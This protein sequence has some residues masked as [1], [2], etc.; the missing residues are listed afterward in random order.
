MSQAK[1]KGPQFNAVFT[2]GGIVVALLGLVLA[3]TGS[4]MNGLLFV[5]AGVIFWLFAK[6]RGRKTEEP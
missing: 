2:W 1:I 4:F 3:A 6:R 5:S